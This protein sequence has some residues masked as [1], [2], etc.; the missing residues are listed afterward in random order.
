MEIDGVVVSFSSESHKSFPIVISLQ[1]GMKIKR[2]IDSVITN[3]DILARKN[4]SHYL[5]FIKR[6]YIN[7]K[8]HPLCHPT[9]NYIKFLTIYLVKA[10]WLFYLS[11]VVTPEGDF[12]HNDNG[13]C[14][15]TLTVFCFF[16][17]IRKA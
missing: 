5:S 2:Y 1:G 15:I 11:V 10:L 3:Y 12:G 6:T 14:K 9:S 7:I 17:L 13:I 8:F 4:T 16:L